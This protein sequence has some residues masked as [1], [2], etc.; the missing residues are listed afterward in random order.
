[1]ADLLRSKIGDELNNAIILGIPRAGVLTADIVARKLGI[2]DF[3]ILIPIKITTADNNESAIGAVMEDGTTYL[4]SR[5]VN[6]LRLSGDHI[7]IER[8]KSY[9]RNKKK[10]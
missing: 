5:E 1:M 10:V 9:G 6:K 7:E 2:P 4:D 3:D 8:E